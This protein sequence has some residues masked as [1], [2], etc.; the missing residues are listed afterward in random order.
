[1]QEERVVNSL[2]IGRH[3][4]CYLF[5]MLTLGDY[6]K[7]GKVGWAGRALA[8]VVSGPK[9]G[10]QCGTKRGAKES[11]QEKLGNQRHSVSIRPNLIM[12]KSNTKRG[13]ERVNPRR[14]RN[15]LSRVFCFC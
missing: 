6:D 11:P 4:R 14:P 7:A 13:Q 15:E 10:A 8:L 5:V 12:P 1:M 9:E 3:I 2:F